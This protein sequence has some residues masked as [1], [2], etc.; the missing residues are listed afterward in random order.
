MRKKIFQNRRVSW[1]SEFPKIIYFQLTQPR[2]KD[3]LN[4]VAHLGRQ[5]QM[6]TNLY[7]KA[8]EAREWIEAAMADAPKFSLYLRNSDE[9]YKS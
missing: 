1:G 5:Q 7:N 6:M 8:A 4:L 3:Q 9:I 2:N